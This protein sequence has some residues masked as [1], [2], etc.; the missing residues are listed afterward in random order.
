MGLALLDVADVI[1]PHPDVVAFLQHVEGEGFLDEMTGLAGGQE[2]RDAILAWLDE[3]G[4][5]CV[6]EIDIT[7]PRF[8]ERPSTLLPLIL[9]NVRN[10]EP[11]GAAA[12]Q[13]VEHA[14]DLLGHLLGRAVALAQ[15]DRR[16]YGARRSRGIRHSSPPVPGS[17]DPAP[18][19]SPVASGS[20]NRFTSSTPRAVSNRGLHASPSSSMALASVSCSRVPLPPQRQHLPAIADRVARAKD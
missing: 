10:F 17:T 5:R 18:A 15:Q 14:L 9:G 19:W 12:G 7:R 2:A 8:R 20:W 11:G 16:G 13:H 4:M 6:G 3:Y 1:R